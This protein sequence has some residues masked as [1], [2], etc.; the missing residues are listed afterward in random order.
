MAEVRR[1]AEVF[2][3]LLAASEATHEYWLACSD[4]WNRNEGRVVELK[5]GGG[6]V[7]SAPGLDEMAD[8]AAQLTLAALRLAYPERQLP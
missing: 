1:T 6:V 3:A 2:E 8:R 5:A 4:A 7:V